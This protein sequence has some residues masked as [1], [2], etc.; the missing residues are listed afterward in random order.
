[1]VTEHQQIID[2]SIVSGYFNKIKADTSSDSSDPSDP[3]E[4]KQS[5]SKSSNHDLHQNVT[6]CAIIG[7]SNNTII[8]GDS[9]DSSSAIIA[10]SGVEIQNCSSTVVL[11]IKAG[12]RDKLISNLSEAVVTRNL[13]A[14]G[15]IHAGSPNDGVSNDGDVPVGTVLDVVGDAIF[16]GNVK[17]NGTI[18]QN[19][20]FIHGKDST[21]IHPEDYVSII[22]AYPE[23]G[24]INIYLGDDNDAKFPDDSRVTIKDVSL[25]FG[26]SSSYNIHIKVPISAHTTKIEQYIN[27]ALITLPGSLGNNG[28]VLDTCG[29]SVTFRY[30]NRSGMSPVWIIEQS[31]RGNARIN[32]SSGI[33]FVSANISA[34]TQLIR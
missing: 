24:H 6:S 8:G 4:S 33:K 29:G 13:Y 5:E 1:M 14:L 34:R 22:Y 16:S 3:S 11:G 12:P 32:A 20:L 25:K 18:S 17:V 15:C 21:T 9:L 19:N 31:F 7:G 30:F 28:Y 27:G 2:G 26:E 23:K 10:C